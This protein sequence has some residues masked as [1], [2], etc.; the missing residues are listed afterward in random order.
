VRRQRRRIALIYRF[1][2]PV[3]TRTNFAGMT[4]EVLD[5]SC[6]ES[7]GV[8]E[9]PPE[10]PFAKGGPGRMGIE[11]AG[12][13]PCRGIGG[14]PQFPSYSSPMIGGQRGLIAL[15]QG[16]LNHKATPQGD[17]R[18]IPYQARNDMVSVLC[19]GTIL[20]WQR[21]PGPSGRFCGG[22]PNRELTW[23]DCPPYN[24]DRGRGASWVVLLV[25]ESER[26]SSPLCGP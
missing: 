23:L 5:T 8:P 16:F 4:G 21:C 12:T 24:L 1:P 15:N 2:L 14:V 3:S 26:S 13:R 6:R 11:S 25:S 7:E 9:T 18:W 19:E 10:S 17:G 20:G 22:P